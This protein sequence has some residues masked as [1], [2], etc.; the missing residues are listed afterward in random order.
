MDLDTILA[1]IANTQYEQR[2]D[3][4]SIRKYNH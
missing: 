2:L 1:Q 4:N 3:I